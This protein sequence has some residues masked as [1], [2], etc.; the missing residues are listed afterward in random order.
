M[1][2]CPVS[3]GIARGENQEFIDMAPLMTEKSCFVCHQKQGYKK[4]T[5]AVV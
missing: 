3:R 5:Y 1:T 4:G 2:M